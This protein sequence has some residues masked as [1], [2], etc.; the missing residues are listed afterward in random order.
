MAHQRTTEETR[1]YDAHYRW[2][3]QQAAIEVQ[4]TYAEISHNLAVRQRAH[5]PTTAQIQSYIADRRQ[6]RA[7][8]PTAEQIHRYQLAHQQA[9]ATVPERTR[10]AGRRKDQATVPQVEYRESP[11]SGRLTR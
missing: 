3:R 7:H 1:Y 10:A 8:P 5:L 4:Q 9:S 6:A 2:A 11:A